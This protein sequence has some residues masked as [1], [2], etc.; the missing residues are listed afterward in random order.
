MTFFDGNYH[1]QLAFQ[2]SY[3]A[4]Y[5]SGVKWIGTVPADW[6]LLKMKH[7]HKSD[8]RID[9]VLF[10]NGIVPLSSSSSSPLPFSGDISQEATRFRENLLPNTRQ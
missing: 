2:A 4:N 3:P 6:M 5:G 1:H 9:L 10:L 8:E 7:Y